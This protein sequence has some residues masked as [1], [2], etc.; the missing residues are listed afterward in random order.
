MGQG[1]Q[2]IYGI[3]IGGG[4]DQ[5]LE[6][7]FHR[8]HFREAIVFNEDVGRLIRGS[9]HSE[10]IIKST[11]RWAIE[12]GLGEIE[13]IKGAPDGFGQIEGPGRNPGL[14]RPVH[15]QMPFSDAR[16]L[17]TVLLEK[18]GD[19]QAI[20]D[21]ERRTKAI[22]HAVLQRGTPI[23]SAGHNAVAGRRANRRSAM[24][25][26]EFH[27]LRGD[28]VDMGRGN[29]SLGI[30]AFRV[31]IAEVVAKDVDDVWKRWRR[32]GFIVGNRGGHQPRNSQADHGEERSTQTIF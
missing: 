1:R 23:V 10:V 26:G 4:W 24:G 2:R 25:V 20:R 15:S 7:L 12:N 14:H 22:Q 32:R 29:F 13:N 5:I 3:I 30:E 16:R 28:A 17:V 18:F 8:R 11:G 27:P 9:G 31:A 6:C 19:S 21:N